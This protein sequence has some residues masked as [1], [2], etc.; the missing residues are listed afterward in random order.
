MENEM[1]K[2]D[3]TSVRRVMTNLSLSEAQRLQLL[4]RYC[5]ESINEAIN[6]RAH[7]AASL[8]KHQRDG[9][10]ALFEAGRDCDGV[11]YGH[12]STI[13]KATL[14][15]YWKA[16]DHIHY[17]A[18]GPVTISIHAPDAQPE[19]YSIGQGWGVI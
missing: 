10:V 19:N 15:E 3:T 9:L 13:I 12:R 11:C 6:H 4:E 16:C 18:D 5:G 7:I 17:W 1:S 2:L 14:V 8:A